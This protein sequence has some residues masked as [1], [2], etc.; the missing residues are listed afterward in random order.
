LTD[1]IEWQVSGTNE[2]DSHVAI[3]SLMLKVCCTRPTGIATRDR[4]KMS[5]RAVTAHYSLADQTST[6]FSSLVYTACM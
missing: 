1:K 2:A 3:V 5:D 6:G 4:H